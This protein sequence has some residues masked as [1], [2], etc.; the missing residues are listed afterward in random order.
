MPGEHVNFQADDT[1]L[2]TP[3]AGVSLDSLVLNYLR[4]GASRMIDCE[5]PA[6]GSFLMFKSPPG[7]AL[8]LDDLQR[9]FVSRGLPCVLHD[10]GPGTSPLLVFEPTANVLRLTV[11]GEC[12]TA[13][14]LAPDYSDR[15]KLSR[16][17][18]GVLGAL[19]YICL[20][21]DQLA[22]SSDKIHAR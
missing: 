22:D 14:E 3:D 2:M 21:E 12:V 8:M 15:T 20:D 5:G 7:A 16:R 13:A 9:H 4:A 10:E 17:I 6:M 11:D 18:V 1:A 19:N